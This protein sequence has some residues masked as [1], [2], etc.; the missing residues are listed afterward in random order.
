[1]N[2]VNTCIHSTGGVMS[3][4]RVEAEYEFYPEESGE[5]EEEDYGFIF[6]PDGEIKAVFVPEWIDW[7]FKSL[8][9][10]ETNSCESVT[11]FKNNRLA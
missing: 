11:E 2:G 6:G 7:F 9:N 10:L 4:K 8:S 5:I 3:N 1:M